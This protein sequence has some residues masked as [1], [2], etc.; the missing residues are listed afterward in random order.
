M[1]LADLI[2][3]RSKQRRTLLALFFTNEDKEYYL[4]ELER[5]TGIP[6]GNVR[7]ELN[8][9]K[10]DRL[11]TTRKQGNLVLFK[12]NRHHPHYN[13]LRR[14]LLPVVG[15]EGALRKELAAIVGIEVAFIYGSFAA[16]KARSN[17]DI[18]L[19]IIG[20]PERQQLLRQ[21]AALEKQ[22]QREVNYKTY[23]RKTFLAKQKDKNS[24][25]CEV[26]EGAKI[27]IVGDEHDL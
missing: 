27:F 12:L 9:L 1:A 3:N 23:S 4:R 22:F 26:L 10:E 25:V 19:M 11:F 21:I 2:L 17:S 14:I 20:T 24:F 13:E 15:I 8:K 7:R 6:V 5:I 16:G 18:D